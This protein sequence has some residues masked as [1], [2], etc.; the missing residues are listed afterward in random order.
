[1]IRLANLNRQ[2][3]SIKHRLH[4]AQSN[5]LDTG[6]CMLGSNTQELEE[7]LAERAGAQ[8]CA[9]VGSGSDAL[10]MGLVACRVKKICI[11]AQSILS[12]LRLIMIT[13]FPVVYH[14][15]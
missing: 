2:Y 13:I 9:V 6:N 12:S 11:P 1:M 10:Y 4:T 7:R 8:Y 3:H 15:M 5:V 14:N